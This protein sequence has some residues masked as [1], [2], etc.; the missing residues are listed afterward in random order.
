M[1]VGRGSRT[2]VR[3]FM[4]DAAHVPVVGADNSRPCTHQCAAYVRADMTRHR[5]LGPSQLRPR[6]LVVGQDSRKC[7]WRDQHD[8]MPCASP[9]PCD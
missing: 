4:L 9:E 8:A 5:A 7:G 1:A 6:L 3:L 2:V